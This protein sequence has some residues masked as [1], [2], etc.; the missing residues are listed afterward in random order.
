VKT[1]H[2][3]IRDTRTIQPTAATPFQVPW[4]AASETRPAAAQ[5]EQHEVCWRTGRTLHRKRHR[6][7]ARAEAFR[8]A[9]HQ[10]ARNHRESGTETG[11]PDLIRPATP[12]NP[13][14]APHPAPLTH[15][16]RTA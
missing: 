12:M 14:V 11:L 8:S 15:P 9:I 7:R 13:A 3:C 4:K 16:E 10:A 2:V 6:T 5:P 1:T